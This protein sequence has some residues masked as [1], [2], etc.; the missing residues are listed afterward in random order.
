MKFSDVLQEN[1]IN[2]TMIETIRKHIE[3]LRSQKNGLNAIKDKSRID[4]INRRIE[5][6]RMRIVDLKLSNFRK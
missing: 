2:D 1:G 3:N 5:S 6:E 4:D